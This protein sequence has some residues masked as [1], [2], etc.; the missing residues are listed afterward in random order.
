[1]CRTIS[2]PLNAVKCIRLQ[3]TVRRLLKLLEP[4]GVYYTITTLHDI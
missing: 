2:L 4:N 1:M 3:L